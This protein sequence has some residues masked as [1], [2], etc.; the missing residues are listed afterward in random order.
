MMVRDKDDR[1]SGRMNDDDIKMMSS[2]E[3]TEE[4]KLYVFL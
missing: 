4:D 1:G 2:R 3:K